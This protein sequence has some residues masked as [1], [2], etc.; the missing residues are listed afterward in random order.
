MKE[1]EMRHAMNAHKAG[2]AE[3]PQPVKKLMGLVSK[4]M[5]LSAYRI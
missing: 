5:T 3:L 2:A 4:V 1:D